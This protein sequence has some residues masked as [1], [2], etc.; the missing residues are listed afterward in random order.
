MLWLEDYHEKEK[1]LFKE[2]QHVANILTP[3]ED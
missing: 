3:F 1:V 2:N